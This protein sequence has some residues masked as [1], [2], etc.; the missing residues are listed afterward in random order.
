MADRIYRDKDGRLAHVQ[1]TATGYLIRYR[2][3]RTTSI[4]FRQL[5]RTVSTVSGTG[6]VGL[7]QAP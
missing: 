1:P 7:P 4:S 2:D 6:T 3:G 5:A